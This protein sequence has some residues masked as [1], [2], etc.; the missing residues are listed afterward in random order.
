ML[1]IVILFLINTNSVMC[2]DYVLRELEGYNWSIL[3]DYSFHFVINT[4]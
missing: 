3:Q 4:N 1:I 2:G